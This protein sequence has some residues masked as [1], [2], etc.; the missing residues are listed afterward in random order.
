MGRTVQDDV[1]LLRKPYRRGESTE[2]RINRKTQMDS[3][4][5]C[6]AGEITMKLVSLR[7]LLTPHMVRATTMRMMT[8]FMIFLTSGGPLS[9]GRSIRGEFVALEGDASSSW[10]YVI[11]TWTFR[12]SSPEG[13]R[14]HC[15]PILQ[16][17]GGG[18]PCDSRVVT[19]QSLHPVRADREPASG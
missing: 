2:A 5:S 1:R 17:R 8:C 18:R 9:P 10:L 3:V 7:R 19:A 13:T 16:R 11:A 15:V 12:S 4:C 14:S 6:D